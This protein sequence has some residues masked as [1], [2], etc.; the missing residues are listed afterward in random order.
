[1]GSTRDYYEAIK[2]FQTRRDQ[3]DREYL[4]R[5]DQ[6]RDAAGSKYYDDGMQEARKQREEATEAAKNACRNAI[7]EATHRMRSNLQARKITPPTAEQLAI[8]QTLKLRESVTEA[9]LEHAAASMGGNSLAIGV[10][11]EISRRNGYIRSY[12]GYC[13]EFPDGEAL[14][15]IE[16]LTAGAER[17]MDSPAQRGAL[18]AAKYHAEHYGAAQDPDDL[19]RAM[20]FADRESCISDLGSGGFGMD[21]ST[22]EG[23][24][25]AVDW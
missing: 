8:L 24:S 4:T 18:A 3:I 20:P 11:A 2:D 7:K 5:R 17:I 25:E 21:R 9:E 10:I 22:I 15:I 12:S 16:N 1:M 14:A 13:K 19:P 23:F 6:L